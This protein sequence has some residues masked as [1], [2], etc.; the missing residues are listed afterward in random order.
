MAPDSK[1]KPD[2]DGKHVRWGPY[3][4]PEWLAERLDAIVKEEQRKALA[5]KRD[6]PTKSQIVTHVLWLGVEKQDEERRV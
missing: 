2:A 3:S 5:E 1:V 4:I 6:V